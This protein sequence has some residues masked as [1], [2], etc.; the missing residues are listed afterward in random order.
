MSFTTRHAGTCDATNGN[1]FAMKVQVM[2][3][4]ANGKLNEHD[5]TQGVA[6]LGEVGFMRQ[7]DWHQQQVS[8]YDRKMAERIVAHQMLGKPLR[9]R[10]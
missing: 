1:D 5:K 6:V 3:P 4:P 7:E 8:P 9:K 10:R 2:A